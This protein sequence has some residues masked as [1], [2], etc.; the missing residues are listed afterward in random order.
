M[1]TKIEAAEASGFQCSLK[2]IMA[3]ED[4]TKLN[5]SEK[6]EGLAWE[7]SPTYRLLLLQGRTATAWG[8]GWEGAAT[9]R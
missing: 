5:P 6:K 7:I 3:D 2:S 9:Y 8:I 1:R 4:E